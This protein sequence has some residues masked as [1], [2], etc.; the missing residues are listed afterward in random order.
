MSLVRLVHI[1]TVARSLSFLSGQVGFMKSK[2]IDVHVISSPS[3]ELTTFGE[4][5]DLSVHSVD[6]LRRIA[7]LADLVAVWRLYIILRRIQPH[8]VHAHFPKG[9]LLGILAAWLACVP[10]RL[11]Q[12]HGLRYMTASGWKRRVLRW[13]EWIS[14]R[15]ANRVLCVSHS[16]RNIVIAEGFCPRE[17]ITVLLGG[18]TNGV[19]SSVRFNPEYVGSEAR[20]RVRESLGIPPEAP[21]LGFVGRIV[22]DKGIS[23]LAYAWEVLHEEFPNL[24]LIIVGPFE[25]HD[26][27]PVRVE[28]FLREEKQI[29][30]TGQV[31]D[32]PPLYA[33]MDLLVLPS[34]REGF[35]NVPL[36]AGAMR[37]AVVATRIPGTTE[38]VEDGSTGTLVPPHDAPALARAIRTYIHDPGL[39]RRHG[40]AG[41]A[42]VLHGFTQQPLW[43]ALHEF[44][45][46]LIDPSVSGDDPHHEPEAIALSCRFNEAET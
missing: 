3:R 28:K 6:M 14:C 25:P 20:S 10:V 1:T 40:E 7:P 44:Y 33:S 30:L 37:L 2:G 15:L 35:P 22:K 39:R 17:K 19:D 23:E 42:R 45:L 13:T 41:R 8:V 27:V 46:H 12:V 32:T 16:V 26:P 24:Q 11:Y 4:R 18:T 21:V 38:A 5:E 31:D 43:Q 36:E 9:G 34:H 29:H